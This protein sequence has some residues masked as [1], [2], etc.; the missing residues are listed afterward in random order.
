MP[1]DEES[2]LGDDTVESA[3]VSPTQPA[4]VGGV[5]G[6]S[7]PAL[8]VAVTGPTGTSGFGL[9]PLLEAESRVGRSVGIAR[10]PVD[11]WVPRARS[12][13]RPQSTGHAEPAPGPSDTPGRAE[14]PDGRPPPALSARGSRADPEG[15][16]QIVVG[17]DGSPNSAAALRWANT[18]ARWRGDHLLAVFAWGFVQ[19]GHRGGI[20][21]VR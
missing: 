16:A 9:V 7:E 6:A 8:V 5:S 19:P 11:R 3:A 21:F 13:S 12:S 14:G 2:V 4:A 20:P 18:E 1:V 10:R 15:M 17:V